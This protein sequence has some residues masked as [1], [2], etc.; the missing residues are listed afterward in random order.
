VSRSPATSNR[1]RRCCM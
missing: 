1:L